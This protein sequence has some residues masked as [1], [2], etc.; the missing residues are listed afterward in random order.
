LVTFCHGLPGSASAVSI[1]FSVSHDHALRA[2]RTGHVDR[3]TLI[4]EFGYW[5]LAQASKTKS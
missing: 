1:R 5:P 4:G 2:N 3:Q